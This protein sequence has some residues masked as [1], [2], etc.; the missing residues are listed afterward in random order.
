MEDYN[1]KEPII[2]KFDSVKLINILEIENKFI[3]K[4]FFNMELFF[5]NSKLPKHLRTNTRL[6]LK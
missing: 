2:T 4:L 3:L 1:T 5:Q 6:I